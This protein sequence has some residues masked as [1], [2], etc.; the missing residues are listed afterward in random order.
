M[1]IRS[2][3]RRSL[4][5]AG[6]QRIHHPSFV[7]L[8]LH[9]KVGTVIDVGANEG[10]YG[11]DLREEGYGG[12]IVSFEPIS[13]VCKLLKARAA[14]DRRWEAHQFGVGETD[15]ELSI[16][17]SEKTVFSSFKSLTDYSVGNFPGAQEERR[18]VVPVVRLDTFLK[19]RGDLLENSFLKVD[20]QGF[21]REVL[22]GCGDLLTRFRGIQLELPL[23]QLYTDQMLLVPMI[24]WMGERGFTVA[25]VKENGFDH[26]SMRLLELDVLFW[27]D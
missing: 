20:T 13:A 16:S 10:Q 15:G 12:T 11:S 26:A 17:V 6:L 14:A 5:R 25:M 9:E 4:H 2:I 23:R 21:E 1:T 7:E 27:R 8:L 22:A 24:Q 3:A 18:E 19:D